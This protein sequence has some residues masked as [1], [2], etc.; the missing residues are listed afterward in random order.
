MIK[1]LKIKIMK[2]RNINPTLLLVFFTLIM[3]IL[4][5]TQSRIFMNRQPPRYYFKINSIQ[6]LLK[7]VQICFKVAFKIV[8]QI[9]LWVYASKKC[10]EVCSI[11]FNSNQCLQMLLLG[12]K[13]IFICQNPLKILIKQKTF[14]TYK[15]QDYNQQYSQINLQ[16]LQITAI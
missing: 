5:N 8:N 9:I 14:F 4:T 10:K 3:R 7:I 11:I 12:L 6:K 1:L 13:M 2:P 16:I 15:D